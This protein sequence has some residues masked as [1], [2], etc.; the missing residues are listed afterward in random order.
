MH[1]LSWKLLIIA[2]HT[3]GIFCNIIQN[4]TPEENTWKIFHISS[5]NVPFSYG[6]VKDILQDKIKFHLG[7][8]KGRGKKGYGEKPKMRVIFA[9]FPLLSKIQTLSHNLLVRKT[10]NHHHCDCHTL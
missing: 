3:Y 7:R 1:A 5:P 9:K 8:T 2:H 6:K 10:S 4:I